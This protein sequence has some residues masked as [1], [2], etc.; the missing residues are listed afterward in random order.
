MLTNKTAWWI[1]GASATLGVLY[2]LLHSWT[3]TGV[4]EVGTPTMTYT[5]GN[6]GAPAPTGSAQPI[7]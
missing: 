1:A 5:S 2:W 4:I 6:G 3:V 7:P